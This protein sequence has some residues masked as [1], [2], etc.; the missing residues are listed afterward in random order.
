MADAPV[1]IEADVW[2]DWRFQALADEI[3]VDLY[4]AV[5]R[6]ARL[7]G[8][9]TDRESPVLPV[10]AIRARLGPRGLEAL[11]DVAELGER[12]DGG[13]RMRGTE[14][15]HEWL[16]AARAQRQTA[17]RARATVA[18]RDAGGRFSAG[19]A[20]PAAAGPIVSATANHRV[21]QSDCGD[22]DN[23]T[24][25]T[26]VDGPAATSGPPAGDQLSSLFSPSDQRERDR[27][28]SWAMSLRR[29]RYTIASKLWEAGVGAQTPRPSAMADSTVESQALHLVQRWASE[30]RAA[31]EDPD[32]RVR[33]RGAHLL[34]VL[35]AQCRS[36]Q[37]LASLRETTCWTPAVTDWAETVTPGQAAA[38]PAARSGK[39][40]QRAEEP[41]RKL[42]RLNP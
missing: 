34:T 32:D 6:M 23:P 33:E 17:G 5:G 41:P 21:S 39:P 31:G 38:T 26:T 7:W 18:Q 3:G 16:G 19:P 30:A 10:G 13:V 12:V 2:D 35:A 37:S 25:G 27:A 11:C 9:C 4:S 20:E 1:R 24:S 28:K 8:E 15:R 29:D 22:A 40:F 36:R 14:G 42:K